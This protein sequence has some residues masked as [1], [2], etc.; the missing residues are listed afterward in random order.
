MLGSVPLTHRKRQLSHGPACQK[1]PPSDAGRKISR[2]W[3]NVIA[4]LFQRDLATTFIGHSSPQY[5][6]RVSQVDIGFSDT[7]AVTSLHRRMKT[8]NDKFDVTGPPVV[9]SS[10]GS[11]FF[12]SNEPGP[13]ES[14]VFRVPDE[15]GTATRI[16]SLAGQHQPYPSPDGSTV[17]ILHRDDV[18]PN[19][20][21]LVVADGRSAER[22]ITNSP[23]AEFSQR[24]WTR[25]R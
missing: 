3:D 22:R 14:H 2:N 25:A 10:A 5:G 20:L 11:I 9:N 4:T 15:G 6:R 8:T 24:S 23:P 17:A 21:Y 18:S 19:E 16:S 7:Q 12:Q 1:G 13:Y